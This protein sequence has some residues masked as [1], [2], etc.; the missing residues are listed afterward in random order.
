MKLHTYCVEHDLGFAPNPFNQIC[1]LA[2]CAP[3]IRK[4]AKRGDLIVGRSTARVK[5][6]NHLVYWMQVDEIVDFRHYDADPRF[7][8]KKPDMG[9]STMQRYGDNIYF[10]DPETGLLAQRDSF[11]SDVGGEQS[12]PD[13]ETDTGTTTRVLLGRHFT[14]FGGDGP[15]IPER[16]RDMFNRRN[17][18]CNHPAEQLAEM[19]VWLQINQPRGLVGLPTDWAK[20][21]H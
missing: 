1:S 4:Y 15:E 10:E 21:E 20:I 19:T 17:R 3:Q 7:T 11:H 6:Q 16:L 5:R 8:G 9:G 14:Y 12:Q 13:I 2:C 18:K